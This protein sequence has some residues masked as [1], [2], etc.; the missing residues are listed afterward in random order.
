MPQFALGFIISLS[1]V[2]AS[3]ATTQFYLL[4]ENAQQRI[5]CD[6]LEIQNYKIIRLPEVIKLTGISRSS[7]YEL[8]KKKKVPQENKPW[9][10]CR[11]VGG[12]WSRRMDPATHR[13][14]LV[15]TKLSL[16]APLSNN[17]SCFSLLSHW[18][19]P[20]FSKYLK[21]TFREMLSFCCVS[22]WDT[23][24]KS[25]TKMRKLHHHIVVF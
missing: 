24:P 8:I 2:T 17:L 15:S 7:I 11:R 16:I 1:L 25:V 19:P 12:I 9:R 3:F 5:V 23:S 22:L 6:Y 13:T 10:S 18:F 4:P 20:I 21:K 14:R